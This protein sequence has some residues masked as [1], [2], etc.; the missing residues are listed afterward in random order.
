MMAFGDPK[1]AVE[2][3]I[4]A[5][6]A[7]VNCK[8]PKNLLEHPLCKPHETDSGNMIWRGLRIRIGMHYGPATA[9]RN[10]VHGRYDYFGSTCNVQAVSY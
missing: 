3:G 5:Q 7:L 6:V 4:L 9:T 2:F 8:W 10:E 1:Q